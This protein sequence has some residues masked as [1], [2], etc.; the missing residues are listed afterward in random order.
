MNSNKSR[1]QRNYDASQRIQKRLNKQEKRKLAM[2]DKQQDLDLDFDYKVLIPKKIENKEI[3]MEMRPLMKQGLIP[4]PLNSI[5]FVGSTGSGKTNTFLNMLMHEQMYKDYFDEVYLFSM[6][7]KLDPLFKQ[8]GLKKDNIIGD[9]ILGKTSEL[10]QQQ[11]TDLEENNFAKAKS[12]MFI[13]ED[14]TGNAKLLKSKELVTVFTMGRH[15]KIT[16]VIMVHKYKSIPP[17]IRLNASQ[18]AI[19]PCAGSQQIQ[20]VDDYCPAGCHKKTFYE[21]LEYAW[22]PSDEDK[23]PFFLIDNKSKHDNKNFRKGFYQN[24]IV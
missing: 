21:M 2:Q 11:K 22:K 14:S 5:V 15:L 9:D 1:R 7:A 12:L 20:L 8:A 10:L 17:T 18:L 3:E 16:I 23:R 4:K 24:L 6:S 13:Y 19:F